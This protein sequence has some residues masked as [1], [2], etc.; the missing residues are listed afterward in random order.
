[1][2][3]LVHKPPPSL[4]RVVVQETGAKAIPFCEMIDLTLADMAVMRTI[5]AVAYEDALARGVNE[6]GI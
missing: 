1:M 2:V 6:P 5:T 4:S 3:Q